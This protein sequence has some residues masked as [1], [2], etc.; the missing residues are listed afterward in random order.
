[1]FTYIGYRILEFIVI[2]TPYPVTY[3]IAEFGARLWLLS[4]PS[5]KVAKKNVSRVLGI[6]ASSKKAKRLVIAIFVNWAKNIADFLK[7]SVISGEKLKKRVEIRGLDNLDSALKKGKGVVIF[8]AHIGNFEWGACRIAIEGYDIWGVSL[9]RKS[10][11]TN[12]FFESKRLSKGLNTL[13]INRM[14]NVFR[15]LKENGIVA[16]PSDWDPTGL[17]AKPFTFFGKKAHFPTGAL[18]IALK[19]GAELVPS[20]IWR[21]GKYNHIQVIDRPLKLIREGDKE[22]LIKENMEMVLRIMEKY[23]SSHISEWEMF[24][25]IWEEC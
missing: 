17:A 15:I 13:Y 9:V 12:K 23:I 21:K 2:T 22:T 25:D 5:V 11:L 6:D 20:F 8:T 7:H 1:M 14:L 24:H 18:Q 10:K 16:I 3:L 19:S 4:I